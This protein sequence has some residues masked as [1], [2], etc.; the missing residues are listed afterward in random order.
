M[1]RGHR[2]GTC[3]RA[4][5][6]DNNGQSSQ[7]TGPHYLASMAGQSSLAWQEGPIASPL[8]QVVQA[9]H[10]P[11]HSTCCRNLPDLHSVISTDFG[12]SHRNRSSSGRRAHQEGAPTDLPVSD[13]ASAHGRD[14]APDFEARDDP[15]AESPGKEQ[16]KEKSD[17]EKLSIYTDLCRTPHCRPPKKP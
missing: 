7:A 8:D 1:D 2:A 13:S 12:L 10:R 9:G 17:V 4:K 14:C 6:H 3:P 15:C 16:C 11:S 5:I